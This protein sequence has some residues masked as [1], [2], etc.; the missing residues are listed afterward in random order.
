MKRDIASWL[1]AA[2]VAGSAILTGC[3]AT[4]SP[5]P[6]PA[7]SPDSA[8]VPEPPREPEP[9]PTKPVAPVQ[10]ASAGGCPSGDAAAGDAVYQK[11][12]ASCHGSR[13][14]GQGPAAAGLNPTPARHDDGAYMNAL[15]NAHLVKVIRS[16]GPAVGKSPLMA[17]WGGVLDDTQIQDVVA[18]VRSLAKP[19][20]ECAE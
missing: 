12:C 1:L 16:G 6:P 9:A 20:Y 2:M 11:Y 8:P 5:A 19:P 7:A 3:P 14:D 13:G 18:F 10:D 4:E 15:S 17:P